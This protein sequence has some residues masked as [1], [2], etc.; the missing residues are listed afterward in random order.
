MKKLKLMVDDL[1]VESFGTGPLEAVRGTVGGR[2][3]PAYTASCDGTCVAS[4]VSCVDTCQNTCWDSCWGTCD[5]CYNTCGLG[6]T[7]PGYGT[8]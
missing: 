5:T 7:H 8:C 2:N 6:C 4:C 3:E 1:T